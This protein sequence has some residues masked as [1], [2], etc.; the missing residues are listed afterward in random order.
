MFL[1][2]DSTVGDFTS[3][4]TTERG[5][6]GAQLVSRK[7][8]FEMEIPGSPHPAPISNTLQMRSNIFRKL[9][10]L[11]HF[12]LGGG[13]PSVLKEMHVTEQISREYQRAF[14]NLDET[15]T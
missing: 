15:N 2:S 9:S 10:S 8:S 11:V 13:V 5:P 12:T 6:S 14:P 1:R 3:V 4:R 7:D